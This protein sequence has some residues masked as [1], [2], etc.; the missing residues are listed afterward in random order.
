M[1]LMLKLLLT[2]LLLSSSALAASNKQVE[3]FL[4][5]SFSNNPAIVDLQVRVVEK[6]NVP[7][8]KSWEA[9][10]VVV[11]ATVKAK[12]KNR[13]VRQKMIW[14]TN[15]DVITKD[16][17]SLKDGES[18][19][20]LV[21]PAFKNEYYKKE[22]LIYGNVN[23][24]H[25][26]AIFSDP[27]CPFC[28]TFVPKVIKEMKKQP[29]KFAIYYYHFPLANLHP[30]AVE[31]S[32]AAIAAELQGH[33]DVILKMYEVEVDA[34]ERN[35]VKILK[36]FNKTMKTN[37]KPSDLKRPAVMKHFK[38]DLS[39]ADALMVGGTPTMFFDG[40]QDKSKRKWEQVK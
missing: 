22:N 20:A 13:K 10:I 35:I 11:D 38:N 2:S 21:T 33:K 24:K 26:I 3:E 36:A 9:V 7:N 16:L 17:V 40:K 31:L 12:P 29:N 23:A 34:K 30:A 5:E 8:L 27:L 28:Q 19:K 15:G 6:M 39:I 18:L 37:I 32:Q 14:F 4:K 1:S 25:K